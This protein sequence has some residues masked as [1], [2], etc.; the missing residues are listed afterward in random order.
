MQ[1]II[2]NDKCYFKMITFYRVLLI[3]TAILVLS[4]CDYLPRS[5]QY[6]LT[7][8][9]T[10][11]LVE[12]L[13]PAEEA[14]VKLFNSHQIVAL[15]D[16]H[17]YDE[18]MIFITQLVTTNTFANKTQHLVV[19]FG[20][21]QYQKLLD[22]Y[23]SGGDV[24]KDEIKKIW[25]ETLFFTAWTPNVYADFFHKVR[26]FNQGRTSDKQ[27]KITLAEAPFSWK[28]LSSEEEWRA[29]ANNK[30]SGFSSTIE[31][32]VKNENTLFI[33]GAFHVIE[34]RDSVK[35]QVTPVQWPLLT[36]V[37][38]NLDTNAYTIW[39]VIQPALINELNQHTT[40]NNKALIHLEGSPLGE[41][42]FA[43]LM[44]KARIKLSKL[45]ARDATTKQLFDGMLYLGDIKR[46]MAFPKKVLQDKS[47][48]KTMQ[49]RV[50]MI[51]GRIK[52]KFDEI[53]STSAAH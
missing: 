24:S 36:R 48:L 13:Q 31:R 10:Q 29:I 51:G 2:I 44:P 3:S 32:R 12:N 33:F 17:F 16:A 26:I 50:D 8:A 20:N 46:V 42:S 39:P 34:L 47:W 14:I 49:S 37:S 23:L 43:D 25:R 6:N 22:D 11:T 38:T 1:L 28:D 30:V 52:T 35:K 53:L 5:S 7:K 19:E 4:A 45:H 9:E 18:V 41:H 15:G 27:L 40:K 21:A